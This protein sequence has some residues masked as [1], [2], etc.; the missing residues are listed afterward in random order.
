MGKTERIMLKSTLILL[1]TA[2]GTACMGLPGTAKFNQPVY[3]VIDG[4]R[5]TLAELTPILLA[6]R[7]IIV[8]E[9][10]TNIAHHRAQLRVIQALREAGGQVAVGLEMFRNESQADLDRWVDGRLTVSEF[11]K[12]YDDNWNYPW[13][14]YRMIFEYAKDHRIPMIGLNVSRRITSQVARKGFQ[15]LSDKQRGKLSGIT[16]RVDEAY[17]DYIRRAYDAHVHGEMDFTHFCEAQLV[18]DTVMAIN[19]V[20]YVEKNPEAIIVILCG[21]GHAQKRAIPR[22]IRNRSSFAHVVILPE[23][24]A[25]F[26]IDTA[27]ADVADY[28]L[29]VVGGADS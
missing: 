20:D 2:M 11:E 13:Q 10:H 8:G 27:T 23:I 9:H 17:M 3:R 14:A 15:S 16:C 7:I 24:P 21:A 19:A 12:I 25:S 5:M 28:L 1:I 18:W 26:T 29:L 6:Q 4:R 22:Q